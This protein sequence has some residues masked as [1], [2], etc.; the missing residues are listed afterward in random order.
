MYA[1]G[2]DH[3]VLDSAKYSVV[4]K[5]KVVGRSSLGEEVLSRL[6]A[7]GHGDQGY[8]RTANPRCLGHSIG[9]PTDVSIASTSRLLEPR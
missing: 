1:S 4:I 8:G 7:V 6:L 9:M 2:S 3:I 5:L